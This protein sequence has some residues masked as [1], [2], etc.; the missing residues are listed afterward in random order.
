MLFCSVQKF[1]RCFADEAG[2]PHIWVVDKNSKKVMRRKVTTGK[3]TGTASILITEG[4]ETGE[5]IAVAGVSQLREGM[6]VRPLT[7]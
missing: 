7:K 1:Y 2:N 3:L 4:L 5:T 6:E